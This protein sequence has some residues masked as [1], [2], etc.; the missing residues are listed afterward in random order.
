MHVGGL[1]RAPTQLFDSEHEVWAI[2]GEIIRPRRDASVSGSLRWAQLLIIMSFFPPW[3]VLSRGD[4]PIDVGEIQL[5]Y[6]E[7]S[8]PLISF[9]LPPCWGTSKYSI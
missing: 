9:D 6:D 8:V 1:G 5:F 4:N 2:S 3:L 7:I